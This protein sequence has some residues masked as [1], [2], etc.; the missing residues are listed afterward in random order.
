MFLRDQL[1]E[2][3]CSG[4]AYWH[5]L[6]HKEESGKEHAADKLL[7]KLTGEIQEGDYNMSCQPPQKPSCWKPS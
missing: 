7:P 3:I 1:I 4:Q 5:D 2:T 6:S